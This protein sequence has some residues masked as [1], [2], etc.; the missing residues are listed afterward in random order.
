LWQLLNR[1]IVVILENM[2]PEVAQRKCR[3]PD[4]KTIEWLAEDYVRHL[5]H[6]IHQVLDLEP[7][8]YR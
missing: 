1:Q 3:T 7:Y 5:Q 6:H 2:D 8:A 4:P